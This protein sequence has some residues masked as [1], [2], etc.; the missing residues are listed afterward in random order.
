MFLHNILTVKHNFFS[1]GPMQGHPGKA[2]SLS[3]L[4]EEGEKM[5][6]GMGKSGK[7]KQRFD[8]FFFYFGIL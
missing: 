7:N 6:G 2:P 8:L 3:G 5:G 1:Q 4:Q